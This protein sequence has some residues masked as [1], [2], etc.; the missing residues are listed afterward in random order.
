V[1]EAASVVSERYDENGT[2]LLVRGPARALDRLRADV[3]QS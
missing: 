3:A 1:H 2:H